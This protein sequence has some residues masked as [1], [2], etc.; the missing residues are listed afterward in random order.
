[1]SNYPNLTSSEEINAPWNKEEN[2]PIEM[3]VTVCMTIS[4]TFKIQVD[5]YKL[6]EDDDGSTFIDD[7]YCNFYEAIKEQ[8]YLPTEI[9]DELKQ[10]FK[11]KDKISLHKYKKVIEDIQDWNIDD[12]NIIRE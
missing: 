3:E 5:D 6:V 11:Y 1:M 12:L 9:G 2:K 10:D 4:K 7:S 8:V